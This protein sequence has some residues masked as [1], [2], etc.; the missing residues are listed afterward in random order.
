MEHTYGVN[1]HERLTD[2]LEHKY[3]RMVVFPD[4]VGSVLPVYPPPGALRKWWVVQKLKVEN[5]Y[6]ASVTQLLSAFQSPGPNAC[7]T[8]RLC[9]S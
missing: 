8:P 6:S 7:F 2:G 1:V 4:L 3:D 9:G 5:G